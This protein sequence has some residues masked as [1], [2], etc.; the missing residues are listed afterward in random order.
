MSETYAPA[1]LYCE[2]HPNV[3]TSLRC[4][5]CNKPICAKCAVLTP[6]GYKCR[7]CVR[8]QQ[9]VFDTA[10]WYDY[11]VGFVVAAVLSFLGSLIASRLGW[12]ILF[13]APIAGGI[14]AE[15]VRFAIRRRR[16]RGLFLTIA[17]AAA[18]GALVGILYEQFPLIVFL[19]T[20]GGGSFGFLLSPLWQIVY[21][22]MVTST[23]YYRLGGINLRR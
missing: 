5:N 8:G 22:V 10:V 16:A 23:V 18:V 15:V 13:L 11:L 6:T 1:T 4:R 9:K 17:A 19:L 21:A 3:E 20:Q 12:F 7:E 2:N 14:I